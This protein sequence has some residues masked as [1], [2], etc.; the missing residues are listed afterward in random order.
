MVSADLVGWLMAFQP[1]PYPSLL[2]QEL[3]ARNSAYASGRKL[4][5]AL[6]YGEAAVVVYEPFSD[7]SRHGNFLD[8]SYRAILARP[9]WKRRLDKVHTHAAR[10]LPKADR[11]WR[12]L[13][14]SM[15]SDALLMNVFCHPK[16]L[17]NRALQSLL[18]IDG[19]PTPEF[20][21]KA[22]IALLNGHADRTEVDMKLGTL[23]VES[24]LTEADFQKAKDA[25]VECYRDLPDAFE[26]H[27]LPRV[28]GCYA[29]YQLIRNVLAAHALDLNFCVILDARRPDLKEAWYTIMSCVKNSALRT[30]CQ[31]LTWQELGEALP[32]ELQD[33]LDIKYGIVASGQHLSAVGE[34]DH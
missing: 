15:S 34:H 13:D 9:E 17:K 14:S 8:T 29:S 2:R 25:M 30:R 5:H 31:V 21:F 28:T 23:L 6:S 7:G 32:G 27:T 19:A 26:Q 4:P 16:T 24:K 10:S 18:G 22:R 11:I 1:N 12:E 33:F 20:G 3:R